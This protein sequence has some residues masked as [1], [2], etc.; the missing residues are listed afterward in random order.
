M[1]RFRDEGTK[2]LNGRSPYICIYIAKA[3]LLA[4]L[5]ARTSKWAEE[6]GKWSKGAFVK[7]H[8]RSASCNQ[9]ECYIREVSQHA[10]I[11]ACALAPRR[12]LRVCDEPS[13]KAQVNRA[14][15]LHLLSL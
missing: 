4:S 14:R 6:T 3:E 9:S 8:S 10:F 13:V 7:F 2:L 11:Y 12:V 15:L 5:S 1:S